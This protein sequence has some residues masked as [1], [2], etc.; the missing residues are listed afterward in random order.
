MKVIIGNVQS[1][2]QIGG[3]DLL[4]DGKMIDILREYMSVKVPGS[5]FANKKLKWHWN[6]LK[7][8]LT[9]SGKFATGF[10]PV[11]LGFIDET[12]PDLDVEII[13][14]RGQLPQFKKEFVNK[15]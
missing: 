13:D 11:L 4:T 1:V 6:G 10:L 3:T 12:Y 14:E 2:L 15:V 7:Y 8:F 5:F 9:P